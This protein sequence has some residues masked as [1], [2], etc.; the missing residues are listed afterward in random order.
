MTNLVVHSFTV[1]TARK[2]NVFI[3]L[4]VMTTGQGSKTKSKSNDICL[5]VCITRTN[6][7]HFISI[8]QLPT[9]YLQL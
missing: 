1:C 7:E 2:S 3:I 9:I 8:R 5:L 6:T 4:P